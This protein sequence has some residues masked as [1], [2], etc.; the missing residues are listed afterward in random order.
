MGGEAIQTKF[1]LM[2]MY[3]LLICLFIAGF[4]VYWWVYLLHSD[5]FGFKGLVWLHIVKESFE[6][7]LD[8]LVLKS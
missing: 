3:L 6:N 4:E 2:F 8:Y 1:M 5:S 7:E